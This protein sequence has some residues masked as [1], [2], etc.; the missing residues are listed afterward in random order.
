MQLLNERE[1]KV[2]DLLIEDPHI[3]VNQMSKLLDVSVVTVRSDFDDLAD[4]G[5]LIRTR[6]GA[7]PAFH[8]DILARQKNNFTVKTAIAKAAAKLIDDGDT[9][10]IEAGTTTALI[11]R[12]LLGKRNVKVVT[13]STLLL[14]YAR[15][16]PALY[17]TFVG[18]TFSPEAESMVGP[19][20]VQHLELFHVK[21][22]FIGTD[23]FSVEN[24]L[25]THMMEATDV[26]R[27]MHNR[28]DRTVLL[29]DSGKWGQAGFAR[30]IPLNEID[31]LVTDS[32]LPEDARTN[33]LEM[34]IELLI[35]E[36]KE[37]GKG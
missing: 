23:G 10:M 15:S 13:D 19:I 29:A 28:S 34:G 26:V 1:R 14:P 25:T 4:K 8:P 27:A 24:G 9:V 5:Y 2:L 6:G 32:E 7:L 36:S 37:N 3:G 11:G 18:G 16:N 30:I 35:V 20:A 31:T 22:A 12:Y 33:I 21:T 17:L